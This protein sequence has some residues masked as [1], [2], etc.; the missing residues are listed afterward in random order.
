MAT[1]N[2]TEEMRDESKLASAKKM[3]NKLVLFGTEGAGEKII[4]IDFK[5]P[6]FAQFTFKAGDSIITIS[7]EGTRFTINNPN[8]GYGKYETVYNSPSTQLVKFIQKGRDN[9]IIFDLSHKNSDSKVHILFSIDNSLVYFVLDSKSKT[10]KIILDKVPQ[11]TEI[12]C[13]TSQSK[14][15]RLLRN[16]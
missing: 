6:R 4:N 1:K 10:M 5:N 8:A 12:E 7:N 3:I 15:I 13:I 16:E 9:K 14:D 11:K 2:Y